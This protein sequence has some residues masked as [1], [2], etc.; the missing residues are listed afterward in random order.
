M[1]VHPHYQKRGVGSAL[2]A[3]AL[4]LAD[5]TNSPVFIRDATETGLPLYTA[6]GFRQ[7][8]TLRFEYKG[9]VALM[10]AMLRPAGG[11]SDG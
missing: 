5:S 8:V 11:K 7:V 4:E 3:R 1:C 2:M 9:E 10:Y 6:N